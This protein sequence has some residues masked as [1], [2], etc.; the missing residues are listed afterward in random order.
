L[1]DHTGYKVI[2]YLSEVSE[3]KIQSDLNH[4]VY[5]GWNVVAA[6]GEKLILA[7]GRT[8]A[9]CGRHHTPNICAGP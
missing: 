8:C 9:N 6:V 3:Q 7:R 1:L 5:E 4:L 2:R